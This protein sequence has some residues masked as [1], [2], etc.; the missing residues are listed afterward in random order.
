MF[1]FLALYSLLA[2]LYSSKSRFQDGR[3]PSV[4]QSFPLIIISVLLLKIT[5]NSNT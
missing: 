5:T 1:G 4:R 3:G 2:D